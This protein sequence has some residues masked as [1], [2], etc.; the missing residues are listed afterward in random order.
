MQRAPLRSNGVSPP[1]CERKRSAPGRPPPPPGAP[2]PAQL[3]VPPT[4]DHAA[5][6]DRQSLPSEE[7]SGIEDEP[8]FF[9]G[10]RR[11][12][13]PAQ[14]VEPE[15][16]GNQRRGPEPRIVGARTSCRTASE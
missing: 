2:G 9:G 7:T 12:A 15:S 16:V 3:F 10:I 11:A 4:G 1:T 5:G 14:L 13:R 8:R 6:E